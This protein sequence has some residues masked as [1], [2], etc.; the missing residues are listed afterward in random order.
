MGRRAESLAVR[1]E[2]GAAGLTAY[3]EGLSEADW[4]SPISPTDRRTSP[5]SSL[6]RI[7]PFGA[8]GTTWRVSAPPWLFD[9]GR[10]RVT[11]G[12]TCPGRKESQ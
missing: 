3:A 4:G 9:V 12:V 10:P 2:E 6:R 5:L 1:I 11:G 7:T 8:V